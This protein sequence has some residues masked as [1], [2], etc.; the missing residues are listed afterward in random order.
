ME[1]WLE[2]NWNLEDWNDIIKTYKIE[3][4]SGET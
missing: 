1:D 4:K 2:E 3:V